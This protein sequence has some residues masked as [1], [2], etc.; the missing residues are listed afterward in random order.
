MTLAS[1]LIGRTETGRARRRPLLLRDAQASSLVEAFVIIG[2]LTI[3]VTR[4]YLHLTGYPQVGGSTLHVAHVL[5]GGLLMVAALVVVFSF[6]GLR[7]RLLAVVLGGIGFG[8]FLDEVGK[9]VTK[10]NDYF[11]RPAV[12]IMYV[13]VV[14]LLLLNRWLHDSRP[15][16]V[17]EDISNA[18]AIAVDGLIRGLPPERRALAQAQLH[19]AQVAGADV[20]AIADIGDLLARCDPR[21]PGRFG[22]VRAW[23]SRR[24]PSALSSR[25]A[26][27][28]AAFVLVLFSTSGLIN[29]IVTLSSDLEGAAGTITTLG[30]L[31]GTAVACVLSWVGV[32]R[33]RNGKLWPLQFLRAAALVTV[34]LTQVFDF[35]AQEFGALLNVVVGLF[36][37]AVLSARIAVLERRAAEAA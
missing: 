36:A 14:V 24:I 37:L 5:W 31:A 1:A 8:L 10:T 23:E 17:A 7:P 9:F 25:T 12:A 19:R 2:V 18:A 27:G 34:L 30:Q 28:V 6:L 3:L 11:Y 20:A 32:V 33:L 13:V 29:A 15:P 16:S 4:A 22:G 26:V 21:E 35:V